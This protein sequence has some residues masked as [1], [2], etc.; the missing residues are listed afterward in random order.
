MKSVR[1]SAKSLPDAVPHHLRQALAFGDGMRTR[2]D[3]R[4][5]GA[6][7]VLVDHR[8]LQGR[9]RRLT[10]CPRYAHPVGTVLGELE[11][12]EVDRDH[13]ASDTLAESPIS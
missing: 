13:R 3:H 12:R 7:A 1:R 2:D 5:D 4:T 10:A 11:R 8:H 6:I 9:R